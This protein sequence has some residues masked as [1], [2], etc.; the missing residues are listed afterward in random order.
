MSYAGTYGA[1]ETCRHNLY[2]MSCGDCSLVGPKATEEEVSIA[3]AKR[4]AKIKEVEDKC[5]KK[6]AERYTSTVVRDGFGNIISE[7]VH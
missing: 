4:E 5:V 7:I 3:I 1:D 2:W 6:K